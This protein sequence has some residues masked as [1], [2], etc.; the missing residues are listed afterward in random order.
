[1][2][3][4]HFLLNLSKIENP[5]EYVYILDK[6]SNLKEALRVILRGAKASIILRI[7]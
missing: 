2:L 7:T 4:R 5:I 6:I 1:M 3:V